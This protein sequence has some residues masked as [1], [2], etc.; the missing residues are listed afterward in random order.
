MAYMKDSTGRRLDSFAVAPMR[1]P[2]IVLFGDSRTADCDFT[3]AT[4]F[5]CTNMSWFDWGQASLAQGPVFDVVKN[6]GIGG[7]TTTQMQARMQA[8]VLAYSPSHMTIWG[9]TNDG[10]TVLA[11]V[12]AT[13]ARMAA[14][15]DTARAAGIYTFLISE[16]TANT[17]GLTYPRHVQYYNELLR[18]YA[19]THAGV[20]F[21]DFNS[22]IT[23]P[24]N[25]N[26]FNKGTMLRDGLHLGPLGASTI[27]RDIVAKQL[28]RFS[29]PLAQLPVSLIDTQDISSEV[30]NIAPNPLMTGTSGTI[31]SG[32]TG[33]LPSGWT[34]SGQAATLSVQ[35]RTDG[36]GSDLKAVITASASGSFFLTLNVN[37]TRLVPG[38][39]YVLEASM[40]V[41]ATAAVN[42]VSLTAQANVSA[43]VYR[44]G[45]GYPV[46]VA[47]VSDSLAVM[48]D[49]KLRSRVFTAPAATYTSATIL[50][51]V[52]FAAAGSATVRLGRVAL[53]KVD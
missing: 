29:T 36:I 21:W 34:S 38:Q 51:R 32:H 46:Q 44:Y 27:G 53:K 9:G 16:T 11:D 7:N 40:G 41:D 49:L 3:D 20:E 25:V 48:S 19:A 42:A 1:K 43:T 5:Y 39:K 30:R 47:G 4:N 52:G 45:F 14:M 12:D 17:K 13:F 8:D 31:G 2:T 28:A 35:A 22:A 23:D 37:Q 18:G 6:A 33:T 10:W 50:L 24:T 26:G 15:L